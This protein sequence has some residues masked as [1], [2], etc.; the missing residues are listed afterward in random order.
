MP[1]GRHLRRAFDAVSDLTVGVEEELLLLDPQTLRPAPAAEWVLSELGPGPGH[2]PELWSSQ[3]ELVSGVRSSPAA[4]VD[5]LRAARMQ[6]V[7]VLAGRLRIAGIG[8]HPLA[9]PTHDFHRSARYDA[10]VARHGLGARVGALASGLHIHVAVAG[11]DRA[12]AVY[13]AMRSHA[14]VFIALAADAPFLGGQDSGL[15]TVRPML[16]DALPRQGVG[17]GLPSFADLE[18]LVEWGGRTGAIDDPAQLWWECRPNVR[19][20]TI[21]LRAPDTQASLDDAHGLAALAQALVADLC[22]RLD[23][24]ERLP[25]FET[26]RIQ[27]NRW[28]AMRFGVE[29]ELVDLEHDRPVPVREL[30]A[31]L[32][33]RLA[34]H[35]TPSALEHVLALA[36]RNEPLEQRTLAGLSGPAAIAGRAAA[37]TEM[38]AGVE[39]APDGYAGGAWTSAQS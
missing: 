39:A 28:R 37:R 30:L 11:A 4:A 21:E 16:A 8:T 3:V 32:L 2:R 26:L 23:G 1:N 35:L 12:V 38:S 34:R 20:G 25:V 22:E 27:E 36:A 6:L 19:L 18:D 29:A 24:G 5:D 10:I 7:E 17:P 33:E 13:N 15:A 31:G 14:P 9:V